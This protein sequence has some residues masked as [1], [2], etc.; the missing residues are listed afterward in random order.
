[1]AKIGKLMSS[2]L[3]LPDAFS[4]A[5]LDESWRR[6]LAESVPGRLGGSMAHSLKSMLS[7]EALAKLGSICQSLAFAIMVLLFAVIGLHNF[8]NDKVVLALVSLSGLGLW[9]IGYLLGGKERRTPTAIDAI[10]L[11]YLAAN[12][13]ATFASHYFTESLDGLSKVVVFVASYFFF[14]A[15]LE[16]SDR[17]KVAVISALLICTLYMALFGLY[18]YKIGVAPLATWEDPSVLDKTTRIYS[19]LDNPNLFAGFLVPTIPL[20]LALAVAALASKRYLLA[21]APAA[22]SAVALVACILTGSRGSYIALAAIFAVLGLIAA[23]WFFVKLPARF[24]PIPLIILALGV[25][26]VIAAV[27]LVPAL[28][29]RVVSI[30]AGS[31]HSSN[32]Y[33]MTVYRASLEMLK[34]N[35]WFGVGPGNKAFRLAYG[36]YMRSGFDALGTYCVPLEV[37]VECGLV[38]LFV[39]AGLIGS[40]LSRAHM[41]FWS[42]EVSSFRRWLSAGT[43]AAIVGLMAHGLTDTVFYRPQVQFIF[44]LAVA[45]AVSI[46][47]NARKKEEESHI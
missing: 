22:I 4:L 17:R 10:V 33:R 16:Q 12:T 1:M 29:Q 43:A 36:L 2:L 5:S 46:H 34:D 30:F 44:W 24:K 47:L 27:L 37:A 8:V 18:Q 23:S 39:F 32:A 20:S 7:S 9:S 3:R 40:C 42:P 25:V 13:V 19:T 28:N 26:A 15:V 35:W 11:L 41:V 14:T 6:A 31:E 38:G 21:L 45:L